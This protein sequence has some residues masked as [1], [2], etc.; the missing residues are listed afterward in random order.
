MPETFSTPA[1]SP[2]V[3]FSGQKRTF[4]SDSKQY[5]G[6]QLISFPGPIATFS[7]QKRTFAWYL[8]KER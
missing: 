7:G 6:E 3:G 2:V 1:G 5:P 4:T 8:N